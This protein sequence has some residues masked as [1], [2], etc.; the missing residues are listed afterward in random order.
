VPDFLSQLERMSQWLAEN[1]HEREFGLLLAAALGSLA[2][3]AGL[4]RLP[5]SWRFRGPVLVAMLAIVAGACAQ[6]ALYASHPVLFD[7]YEAS[8][9][10]VTGLFGSPQPLIHGLGAPYRY[11]Q[12]GYGPILYLWNWLFLRALG[13]SIEACKAG[14]VASHCA[15]I[16]LMAWV[17]RRKTSRHAWLCPRG[18]TASAVLALLLAYFSYW[19]FWMHP[20][21]HLVLLAVLGGLAVEHRAWSARTRSVVLGVALGVAVN[22]KVTAPIYF[23][24]FMVVFFEREGMERTK[25]SLVVALLVAAVPYLL[26]GVSLPD[27][28]RWTAL[29]RRQGMKS[30]EVLVWEQL[31]GLFY[32]CP[33]IVMVALACLRMPHWRRVNYLH[34]LACVVSTAAVGV[35]A[36]KRGASEHHFMALFPALIHAVVR[37]PAVRVFGVDLRTALAAG[38]VVTLGLA[39]WYKQAALYRLNLEA[40]ETGPEYVQEIQGFLANHPGKTVEM[41]TA[42]DSVGTALF[43]PLLVYA[44]QPYFVDIGTVMDLDSVGMNRMPDEIIR[45]V[46]RCQSDFFLFPQTGPPL[47]TPNVYETGHFAYDPRYI[48][49]FNASY[50]KVDATAHYDV[51]ACAPDA[52]H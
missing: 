32:V 40:R 23:L 10:C 18:L 35:I 17:A 12:M 28:I 7:S 5:R 14:P 26:P 16:V 51:Y 24:P 52:P 2:L 41:G 34:C 49:A 47:H 1:P 27:W 38:Y 43:R 48:D 15:A 20:D 6:A 13:P 39:D 36:C 22:L 29:L 21:A 19:A 44:G 9:A 46:L 25:L 33:L 4:R 45:R 11:V 31:R 37:N 42:G 8:V 50:R 3:F 30:S